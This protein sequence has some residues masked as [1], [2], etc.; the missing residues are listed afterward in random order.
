MLQNLKLVTFS[1]IIFLTA[2]VNFVALAFS[3]HSNQQNSLL[4]DRRKPASISSI[5]LD[6]TIEKAATP[7]KT[8]EVSWM[9]ETEMDCYTAPTILRMSAQYVMFKFRPCYNE[10][11]PLSHTQ[12]TNLTN[13]LRAT[14]FKKM[15]Q[16]GCLI[17]FI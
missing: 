13:H 16:N 9:Q 1:I 7:S 5:T 2:T 14:V 3:T 10:D 6:P 8:Q 11:Q 15:K 17:M 12:L 4:S